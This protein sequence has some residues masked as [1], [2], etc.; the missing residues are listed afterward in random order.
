MVLCICFE[1]SC[2]I[3]A[4]LS[5]SH[6]AKSL[7]TPTVWAREDEKMPSCSHLRDVHTSEMHTISSAPTGCCDDRGLYLKCG[8]R[9][10]GWE[11]L[12][13]RQQRFALRCGQSAAGHAAAGG[14]ARP[15]CTE[16]QES[17]E[18][19]AFSSPGRCFHLSF[20]PP[21]R[22]PG[23]RGVH[24]E[25]GLPGRARRLH[26][27]QRLRGC[28]QGVPDPGHPLP[29]GVLREGVLERRVQVGALLTRGASCGGA[30]L[31][32]AGL[33]GSARPAS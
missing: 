29:A 5:C 26:C 3:S 16:A 8:S 30:S 25:L 19:A 1:K 6:T 22:L 33:P 4:L 15:Q 11:P 14:T 31:S 17:S 10:S 18:G 20:A 24:E 27:R 12:P 13:A 2:R 9:G 21:H 7:C 28:L 32:A 23:D